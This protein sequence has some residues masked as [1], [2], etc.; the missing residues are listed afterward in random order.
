MTPQFCNSVNYPPTPRYLNFSLITNPAVLVPHKQKYHALNQPSWHLFLVLH[1]K[2][3]LTN[4]HLWRY[5]YVI[6][7]LKKD[8]WENKP[9]KLPL[10]ISNSMKW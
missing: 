7:V 10:I 8:T 9:E 6:P 1:L 3:T 2:A 4:T 5:I